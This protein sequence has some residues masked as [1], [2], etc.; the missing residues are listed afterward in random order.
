VRAETA[1]EK[2]VN[3]VH[4]TDGGEQEQNDE[5]CQ[6]DGACRAPAGAPEE[7]GKQQR[8]DAGQ[9]HG[10]G[11]KQ[12]QPQPAPQARG[13]NGG[14]GGCVGHVSLVQAVSE[15]REMTLMRN[16]DLKIPAATR[17]Q[18][19]LKLFFAQKRIALRFTSLQQF[20]KHTSTFGGG[21][22]F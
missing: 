11:I 6:Q 5:Q 2:T 9:Q 7:V 12:K 10:R 17:S 1:Y 18:L 15:Y 19:M 21:F 16:M 3:A 22:P 4:A 14:D 8:D 13:R 20:E